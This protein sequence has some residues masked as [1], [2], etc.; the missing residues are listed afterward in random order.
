MAVKNRPSLLLY[1]LV[2]VL[3]SAMLG[4]GI[5][6]YRAMKHMNG[7]AREMYGDRLLPIRQLS[8]IKYLYAVDVLNNIE[9][10]QNKKVKQKE[11][12][13]KI[14]A[15]N[16]KIKENW[17]AYCKTYLTPEESEIL[18]QTYF[19]K[20]SADSAIANYVS[21]L[22]GSNNV[23]KND[24]AVAT[25]FEQISPL[26]NNIS[27]LEEIQV[28]VSGK[29]AASTQQ[30]YLKT[31][32]EFLWL[33]LLALSAGAVLS[34]T[35]INH[36]KQQ[37]YF[38]NRSRNQTIE[39]RDKCRKIINT[40][41]DA[42]LLLDINKKIIDFNDSA[43][44]LLN[45]NRA[46]LLQIPFDN[47]FSLD[48][49][50]SI[51]GIM[52]DLKATKSKIVECKL[53]RKDGHEIPVEVRFQYE[54]G[55][56][57]IIVARD[58]SE[59]IKITNDFHA[60]EQRYKYLFENSPACMIIYSLETFRILEVNKEVLNRYGYSKDEWSRMTIFDYR[61]PSEHSKIRE[62]V[63]SVKKS[64]STVFKGTWKHLKKNGE[65]MIMEIH[66]HK[67]MINGQ[68]AILGLGRDITKR[69]KAEHA[70]LASETKYKYLFKN[71]PAYIIIWDLQ[72]L[73][74]LEV[75]D[76]VIS[77]YGYTKEEWSDMTVLDYRPVEDHDSIRKFANDLLQADI[78]VTSS[79]WRHLKK[80]GEE[81]I[82]EISSH[83]IDFQ[84]RPAIL[85]LAKDVTLEM[86]AEKVLK[87]SQQKMELFIEQSPASLAMLNT[88][89]EYIATSRRWLSAYNLE[90]QQV[91]GRSY[92][93]VFPNVSEEMKAIFQRCLEGSI[94]KREEDF[95]VGFDG[96]LNWLKWEARPWYNADGIV[97][98]ILI[99][100]EVV[101]ERKKAT[102]F[103]NY[104]F[105]NSPDSILIID[106]NLN[107]ELINHSVSSDMRVDH[108]IGQSCIDI[109]PE[110]SRSIAK[111]AIL[112][113]FSTGETR[114]IE[115]SVG[116]DQWANA[117]IIAVK[118]GDEIQRVMIFSTNI[119]AKKIAEQSLKDSEERHRALIEN[120]SEA[121]LL[122]DATGFVY[123]QSPAVEKISGYTLEESSVTPLIEFVHPEEREKFQ[124]FMAE[125]LDSPSVPRYNQ[126]RVQHK[127]GHYIW[128]EGCML[129]LLQDPRIKAIVINYR[130]ISDKRKLSEYQFLSSMIIESSDDAIIS[131]TLDGVITTWNKG[132]EKIFG[133]KRDEI[134]GQPITKIVPNE[135]LDEETEIISN[136]K[137][138]KSI[139]HFN[140]IR[141]RKDGSF[142]FVSITI[143]PIYDADKKMVGVSKILHDVT[144]IK[145]SEERIRQ[146]E[147]NYRQLFALSPA[148]MWLMDASTHRFLQ[149][150]QSAILTYGY[151]EYEFSEK[152]LEDLEIQNPHLTSKLSSDLKGLIP[153]S[154][155]QHVTKNGEILEV[156]ISS[157]PVVLNGQRQILMMALDKTES[158]LF[159]QKLTKATI[160]AQEE[161]RYEIGGELHDNVCQ[162]LATST[163]FLSMLKGSVPD[164][165]IQYFQQVHTYITMAA[166]E[167]RNLSHRLA[168]AF[169][170][171]ATL[172]DAFRQLTASFNADNRYSIILK[173]NKEGKSIILQRDLQLNLY[174]ILQ[175]QLRNISK[176]ANATEITISVDVIDQV[177][178][179]NVKDNGK[180]FEVQSSKAG[181][182]LANMNRRAQLHGGKVLISSEPGQGCQLKVAIPFTHELLNSSIK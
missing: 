137:L 160:K 13:D 105:R 165:S 85:S 75:N 127:D 27:A 163:I 6:G 96:T 14:D 8:T 162:I 26:L 111:E 100:S 30:T 54:E 45:Y 151:S 139:D 63:D 179:M 61:D 7:N 133:F 88:Q 171:N 148:P 46:E 99:F 16:K 81:M 108:L 3:G 70:L 65:E 55:L 10:L 37:I 47:L 89:F 116:E 177:I 180:G 159:E 138:G 152:S 44:G 153:E 66:S 35:I 136:I 28:K 154:G 92:F 120:L 50:K 98:G 134:I 172:E 149:V 15:A 170:D 42:Y 87:E 161:E 143:S 72:N 2:T 175:E 115:I 82:M 158:K 43:L 23:G 73:K 142:V 174:R 58:I 168:P 62:F 95:F 11:A 155:R 135:L 4:I 103:F 36:N 156:E 40:I 97:G 60:S 5:Y 147:A 76:I 24:V 124:E 79:K 93:D 109:L 114:E 173:F 128:I 18:I 90:T 56:E 118:L 132:A 57:F 178:I 38:L 157:I 110:M 122:V 64:D 34:F 94:E 48:T 77:E 39:A 59:R 52:G 101:T 146:S 141:K 107:I 53:C 126:F 80:N 166:D 182:G 106:R 32:D 113:C 167:I 31:A 123:Y 12:L 33:I 91:I 181:I 145:K 21:K 150:N 69:I 144:E 78:P 169:F 129:N 86:K 176:H 67:V 51:A 49:R 131:K 29:L 25:L 9:Q 1:L 68:E 83:K 41:G 74:I 164:A 104:Q 20:E 119:T 84:G 140:T 125:V 102:Q 117:R 112:D 121:I 71:N 130:D 17:D 22:T 19:I